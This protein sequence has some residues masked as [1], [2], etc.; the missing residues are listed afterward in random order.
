MPF[1]Y[2]RSRGRL[3]RSRFWF[4]AIALTIAFA[5]LFSG[6]ESLGGRASTLILYPAIFW[7]AYVLAARRYHDLGKSPV[8]LLLL[9]IPL[10]GMLWVF[11]EL[12]FAKG[13]EG[14]NQYGPDPLTH[15]IDYQKV[16]LPMIGDDGK[17]VVNDVTGL[18]PIA[19]AAIVAPTTVGIR[20]PGAALS[21]SGLNLPRMRRWLERRVQP[22]RR[23][24]DASA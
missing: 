4:L 18:N 14:E 17:V 23:V 22:C 7:A 19:V 12:A 2:L 1:S 9:L 15:G 16:K 20:W 11:V 24:Q 10:A 8:R 5:L 21:R 13:T 6:L 3:S